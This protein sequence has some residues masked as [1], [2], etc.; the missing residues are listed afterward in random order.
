MKKLFALLIALMM[1][2]SLAAC[3]DNNKPDADKD[4]P[5]TSQ[6]DNQG[7]SENQGG[8]ENNGGENNNGGNT[9]NYDLTT[10]AGYLAKFGYSESDF[11]FTKN[12][13]RTKSTSTGSNGEI[14]LVGIYVSEGMTSDEKN[15]WV[16]D[17]ITLA[18]SKSDDGKVYKYHMFKGIEAEE[19]E[20]S[21]DGFMFVDYMAYRA[22]G[23]VIVVDLSVPGGVDNDNPDDAMSFANVGFK[24]E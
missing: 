1:I 24:F 19:Y 21:Y 10:V 23:K 6:T 20:P 16:N 2:F 18:K 22:N 15:A 4:N 14:I 7:G 17:F 3:G 8:E 11:S 13:T 5:G 12:F 9:E